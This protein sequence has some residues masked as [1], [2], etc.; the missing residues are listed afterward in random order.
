MKKLIA[1]LLALTALCGLAACGAKEEAPVEIDV[2][3]LAAA[4]YE[5]DIYDDILSE[6]PVVAAP[7]FYGYAEGDVTSCVLYQ[8][9]AAA[10]EE[11]FVAQCASEEAA[12]AVKAGAEARIQSQI[13]SYENYV[14]AEVPKLNS[15][16]LETA[17]EYV[18]FVVSAD[19]DAA[20]AIVNEYLG[21]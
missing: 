13:A 12:A 4:L 18:I 20:Q 6:I 17:G 8:S 15:A 21:K 9:T 1:L 3:A 14:P 5:A 19:A 11:I 16:V 10:A 2:T 7:V